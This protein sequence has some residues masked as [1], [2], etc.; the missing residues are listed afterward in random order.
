MSPNQLL[1]H[2]S[3]SPSPHPPISPSFFSSPHLPIPLSPYLPNMYIS[4]PIF[5]LPVQHLAHFAGES[6][7]C[8]RL[9]KKLYPLHEH[10]M[11][12]NGIIRITRDKE[13]LDIRH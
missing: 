6:L 1:F 5:R 10:A 2:F 7:I 13:N 8:K 3:T 9:L 4:L 12:D 11:V